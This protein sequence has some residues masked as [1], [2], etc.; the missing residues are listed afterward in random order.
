MPLTAGA[1]GSGARLPADGAGAAPIQ[2]EAGRRAGRGSGFQRLGTKYAPAVPA[3]PIS[4]TAM[5]AGT[6]SRPV[7]RLAQAEWY[8]RRCARPGRVGVP[9]HPRDPPSRGWT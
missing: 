2:A 3:A 1:D 6:S 4:R 8:A 5:M 7:G 9:Q